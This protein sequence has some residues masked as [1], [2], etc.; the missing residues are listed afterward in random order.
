MTQEVDDINL[1]LQPQGKQGFKPLPQR[2]QSSQ[3]GLIPNP[4]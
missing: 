2:R 3:R 4:T 1:A